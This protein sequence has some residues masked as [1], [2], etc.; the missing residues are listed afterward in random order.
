MEEESCNNPG[1]GS[2]YICVF[3]ALSTRYQRRSQLSLMNEQALSPGWVW[4]N[5]GILTLRGIRLF[6]IHLF[7]LLFRSAA[8]RNLSYGAL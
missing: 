7:D 3:I 4:M 5:S 8:M 6:Y 2:L 1:V